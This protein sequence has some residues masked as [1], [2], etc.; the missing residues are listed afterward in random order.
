MSLIATLRIPYGDKNEAKEIAKANGCALFFEPV[1]KNWEFRGNIMPEELAEYV[2]EGTLIE[3]KE[4][5]SVQKVKS[6]PSLL[7]K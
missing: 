1:T 2:I 7:R 4:V 3:E 5:K 6:A